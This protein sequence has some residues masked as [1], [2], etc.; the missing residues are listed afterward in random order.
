MV[1]ITSGAQKTFATEKDDS[2]MH[3]RL[4][5]IKGA[6]KTVES[7]AEIDN[8]LESLQL[9]ETHFSEEPETLRKVTDLV[10]KYQNLYKAV[11]LEGDFSHE[12]RTVAC[13]LK[14]NGRPFRCDITPTVKSDCA[15]ITDCIPSEDGYG[16]TI[17]YT[18]DECSFDD[19]H[20]IDV[21][22]KVKATRLRQ[23]FYFHRPKEVIVKK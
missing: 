3:E 23:K 12:N 13:R 6:T 5:S 9:M 21:T 11:S 22:L 4:D 17:S 7:V 18:D 15:V 14:L 16:F 10:K 8:A 1:C 2:N 20:W 19:E